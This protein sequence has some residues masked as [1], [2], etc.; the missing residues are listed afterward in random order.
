MA[1]QAEALKAQGNAAFTS[2][3]YPKAIDLFTQAIAL[4]PTNHVLYSNRSGAYAAS[5]QYDLALKDAE[6]TIKLKN[7]WAKGYSRKG[8]ALAFLGRL[9]E[10]MDTYSDGLKMCP[11]DPTLTKALEDVAQQKMAEASDPMAKVTQA[12]RSGSVWQTIAA[13]PELSRHMADPTF[14]ANVKTLQQ[15]PNKLGEMLGDPR[16][17]GLLGALMGVNLKAS[18]GTQSPPSSPPPQKKEPAKEPPKEKPKP[19]EPEPEDDPMEL[20]EEEMKKKDAEK[21]KEAGN[22]AY[23]KKQFDTALAHY[24]KAMELDP[25]NMLYC[26]NAAAVHFEVGDMEKCREMCQKA[27]DLGHEFR[28]D[29]KNMAKAYARMGNSYFKEG[30]YE[31]AVQWYNKSL[32][33]HRVKDV[34][35][36]QIKAEKLLQEQRINAY[37]DPEKA[38]EEKAK[39]NEFFKNNNFPEAVK[40]YSEAIKRNP[41]DHVLYSNRAAAYMKLGEFP[42]ALKDCEKCIDMCPTFVKGYSRKANCHLFLKDYS[43]ALETYEQ[44]LKLDSENKEAEEGIQRTLAAMQ[45]AHSSMTKD[46]IAEEALKDPEVQEI[47]ADPVMRT[48][49][50][51]MQEDPAAVRD[52]LKNPAVAKKI[53]KLVSAGIIRVG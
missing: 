12:L 8:T 13:S 45:R 4:A 7:D 5:G 14:V 46:Q 32:T 49:L 53:N 9:D 29:F 23:K 24:T 26:T 18:N 37:I 2:K 1:D 10:A 40:A 27:I 31:K 36:K 41:S 51:Q 3:D 44:A 15:D 19:S 28:A 30:D 42:T 16:M 17:L 52:H 11:N 34:L 25:T 50:S 43:K 21:E 20:D 47:M 22:E 48:I 38:A 39:G 6:K 35:E 33:E